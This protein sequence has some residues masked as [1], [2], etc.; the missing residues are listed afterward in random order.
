MV[1]K[2]YIHPTARRVEREGAVTGFPVAA[3]RNRA[4][5]KVGSGAYSNRGN[6][7]WAAP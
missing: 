3:G 7:A 6:P 5:A 2:L 4:A 1:W